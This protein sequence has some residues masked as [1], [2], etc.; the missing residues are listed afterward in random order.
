MPFGVSILVHMMIINALFFVLFVECIA[1]Q[2]AFDYVSGVSVDAG[3][4]DPYPKR[5]GER[6]ALPEQ[7]HRRYSEQ[8]FMGAHDAV[9]MRTPE[10]GWSLSGN[11]YFNVSTQLRSGV[12]LIQAQGHKDPA[13]STEIRMCHFNCALMDGGSL[14]EL[15]Q[16]V[17][18]FLDGNPFEV[19][20]LL[21]VNVGPP[22][23][24][25]AK[26]FYESDLDLMSYIPPLTKRHGNMQIDDWPTISEMVE[27]N[28]RLVVF[29][30]KGADEDQVPF[31]LR[32]FDYVFETNFVVD[33]PYQFSC[34]P[35]RPWWVRGY[36]P[37]RL[38]LVNHFLY[39]Q[40]LGFRYPNASYANTTNS[41]GFHVGELGEHA[42]RCRETFDR[43]P[44]Y[45]LVDFFNEGDVFDVECGMN[46]Y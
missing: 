31:L 17:K 14:R 44:N 16:D 2:T 7:Y 23:Q 46:A 26:A 13:G 15:L 45:L 30:D 4:N 9:A 6:R 5:P 41:R 33:F 1:S 18:S 19:V 34:E 8:T 37:D 10:N 12:R 38:S 21:L 43:R 40:F 36:I 28:Q 22:L 27:A 20:T 11:Q 29:L 35:S 25:W 32:E 39:A 42:V 3:N 24:H